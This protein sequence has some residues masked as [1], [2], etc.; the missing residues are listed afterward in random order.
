MSHASAGREHSQSEASQS[1]KI[2]RCVKILGSLSNNDKLLRILLDYACI[3]ASSRRP[4]SSEIPSGV[5]GQWTSASGSRKDRFTYI[6]VHVYMSD[7]RDG[8]TNPGRRLVTHTL[9]M[10]CTYMQVHVF[11]ENPVPMTH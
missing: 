4:S 3:T 7:N 2:D 11:F 8:P 1:V 9:D 6:H 5:V 10:G